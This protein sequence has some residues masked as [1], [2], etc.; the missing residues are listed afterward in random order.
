MKY[1]SDLPMIPIVLTSIGAEADM[2]IMVWVLGNSR[3]IPRN[4]RH[5]VINYE[6]IDWFTFGSNYND[7]IIAATNEASEGQ[8]FVT[9]YAGPS[10]VMRGLLDFEGRFGTESEF[11]NAT[12]AAT[13]A[14]LLNQ[15]GF[16]QT[17]QLLSILEQ[18]FPMPAVLVDQGVT[19]EDYYFRLSFYAGEFRDQNPEIFEGVDLSFDPAALAARLWERIVMPSRDASVLFDR[20]PKMTRM[21]T[22]LSPDEMTR[23]PVFSFNPDLP[24]VSNVHLATF[25]TDCDNFQRGVLVL[26]DGR[27]FNVDSPNQWTDLTA[28]DVPFSR[29]IEVLREEGAPLIAVDN[30]TRISAGLSDGGCSCAGSTAPSTTSAWLAA[31]GFGVLLFG[32]RRRF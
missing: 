22:T 29:R 16:A 9:E 26:P 24:D 4:Y 21:Y 31:I 1:A 11:A 12:D 25:E 20:F 28:R 27:R 6:K 5:T 30:T 13:F 3:A 18:T 19:R 7:V 8:S 17:P 15:R 23:D 32:L 2:G 10:N 14:G